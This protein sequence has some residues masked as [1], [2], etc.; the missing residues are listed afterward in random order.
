VSDVPLNETCTCGI[1]D[2]HKMVTERVL[3]C[4]RCGALRLITERRWRIPLDRVG[5][6][7]SSAS[8]P[9]EPATIPGT[10]DAKRREP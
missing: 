8:I 1:G 7:P 3:W 10:P 2:W 9:E 4:R 6:L 5:D